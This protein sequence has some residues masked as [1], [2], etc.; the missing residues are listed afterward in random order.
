MRLIRSACCARAASGHATA[1]P[2]NTVMNS[3]RFMSLSLET[4][5]RWLKLAHCKRP[6]MTS[7]TGFWLIYCAGGVRSGSA[8]STDV[9]Y[10]RRHDRRVRYNKSGGCRSWVTSGQERLDQGLCYCFDN[11][12]AAAGVCGPLWTCIAH[13][14]LQSRMAFNQGPGNGETPLL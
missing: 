3:R 13:Q 7:G 12:P 14:T 4:S 1:V 6:K 5:Y 11:R 10:F 2:P 9:R 8:M